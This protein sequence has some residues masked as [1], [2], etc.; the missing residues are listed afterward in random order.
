MKN[1]N[2]I[3]NK[4]SL[5]IILIFLVIII[6]LIPIIINFLFFPKEI[7]I[8]AGNTH[9][10]DFNIP[11][12]ATIV[13]E[14][15]NALN[16]NNTLIEKNVDVNL[17]KP[18]YIQSDFE[19]SHNMR[20]SLMGIPVRNVKLS[21]IPNMEVIPCGASVGVRINT[22]GV[23]V[24]GVSS[25]RGDDGNEY[26]PTK[27]ILKAGD[28]ILKMNGEK[29]DSKETLI[30][31][32]EKNDI[33]DTEIRRKDEIIDVS[34]IPIKGEDGKNKIGAWVRDS[35][36]GIGTLTYFNPLT[37]KFG[38]LGHGIV[39]VD[40][41]EIM[42]VKDGKIMKSDIISI[43]K[44][45]KG[46]PGELIGDIKNKESIGDIIKNTEYGIYGQITNENFLLKKTPI[47]IGVKD[48][49]EIGPAII[50][51]NIEGEKIKE[52]DINIEGINKYNIDSSKSMII[53]II[54]KGLLDKTNGIIQ[55]MS[56]S[57][58]IQNGK[59]I[60]AVTHVFVN[61]PQ[62]GYGIFIENMIK[63]E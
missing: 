54:D 58:I 12:V 18:L 10:L 31:C 57:P 60:G 24:L 51:C 56:G 8:I 37:K 20:L 45:E 28:M 61:E 47:P 40:T 2:R 55:G 52:Y 63:N 33:L 35:T 38:S 50:L 15:E 19:G 14:N 26:E 43:K 42:K 32:V 44:G 27:N 21:V 36:Q 22:D 17:K 7:N 53:R 4:K 5:C 11:V 39:D 25:F 62:K 13:S 59:L 46:V 1:K 30:L 49:V 3:F 48:E 23:M 9:R 16:I 6:F 34:I 29:I 41:K